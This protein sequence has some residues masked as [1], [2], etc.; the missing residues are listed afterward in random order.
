MLIENSD[1]I[2]C[3]TDKTVKNNTHWT[4][5][6]YN[7]KKGKYIVI[8]SLPKNDTEQ[9]QKYKKLSHDMWLRKMGY[10]SKDISGIK[11][12][13]DKVID[14]KEAL[15]QMQTAKEL[16]NWAISNGMDNRSAF[17]KFKDALLI[18][19]I[20]YNN[21]RNEAKQAAQDELQAKI[22][23]HVTLY[24]DAK[25]SQDRFAITDKD[26]N[27]LWYG[28]FFDND[29]DYN[30]EQSSGELAAAKK[31]VWLGSKIKEAVNA[32]AIS[33]TLYVDAQWLTYQDKFKQKGSILSAMARKYD[34]DLSVE[35]IPGTE[36]PADEWT[37]SQ[38]FKKWSDNDLAALAEPIQQSELTP[39][40]QKEPETETEPIQHTQSEPEIKPAQPA[41]D[42]AEAE[43][44]RIAEA[45][46]QAEAEALELEMQ[47]T[48]DV[49]IINAEPET[50]QDNQLEEESESN[51]AENIE[52]IT[53]QEQKESE[54]LFDKIEDFGEKIGAARKD[55][56]ERG[57][58]RNTNVNKDTRQK[59]EKKYRVF[60]DDDKD[61]FSVVI[62]NKNFFKT[63]K[64]GFA[65]EAEAYF[66]IPRIEV[67]LN[68]RV[69]R[70]DINKEEYGIFRKW[71]SGK[72]WEIKPGFKTEKEAFEYM[73]K[74][75]QELINFK[76]PR[77]ERP[78]LDKIE[79]TGKEYR[80]GNISP[81]VFQ[82]TF[83]FR[84]GEFGNW[85]PN[86]E[87]QLVLNY[88]YDAFMDLADA[89]Y[90][91]PK[92]ISLG[93]DLSIGFGSRGQGLVSAQAHY[94][95]ERAVINLTRIKGAGALA[96]EWFHAFDHYLARLDGMAKGRDENNF[97]PRPSNE[98][99]HL[100]WAISYNSR[101]QKNILD[102]WSNV[103]ETMTKREEEYKLDVERQ[104]KF[105]N[106]LYEEGKKA[107]ELI[108]K[109]LLEP[110]QWYTDGSA[111]GKRRL[112]RFHK[113]TD[114]QIKQFDEAA[115]KILEGNS[116]EEQ[117]I[118]KEKSNWG[119]S[120][121]TPEIKII[122]DIYKKVHQH[123]ISDYDLSNVRSKG[124]RKAKQELDAAVNS[125]TKTRKVSTHFY[126]DAKK[127]DNTRSGT[128][129]ASPHEMMARCFEAFIQDKI[130]K[131]GNLS[132]YLVHSTH[133]N[134]YLICI[135]T[136]IG[137]Y[138]DKD[139]RTNINN[140]FENLFKEI[141]DSENIIKCD[142]N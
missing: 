37:V 49:T 71:S 55:L 88:A 68:H 81:K 140:S 34:I 117:W 74:Y 93:G 76:T 66:A 41:N 56:A 31:A 62:V 75:P 32:P 138:P 99:T 116:G 61:T 17:P 107:L 33:M 120:W 22:T 128:Y 69:Y 111:Y 89:I 4:L 87:R 30:G 38:G 135:L 64:T 27:V 102:K 54:E 100:S 122:A 104:T 78:H 83:G 10:L 92:D 12:I 11:T 91:K 24:S 43:R 51:I 109:S 90:I 35:W 108:R 126:N 9:T 16:R 21:I 20:D 52:N 15:L 77:I 67:S 124:I 142:K 137:I 28:R 70:S 127:M 3:V 58:K 26:G 42:G 103:I 6:R 131:A 94:E 136:G 1:K 114:E 59:W 40:P 95:P 45:E 18:I 47:L 48:D 118:K 7:A 8:S 65:S 57:F 130:E 134:E 53:E 2:H 5:A 112:S 106:T 121:M 97:F 19:G 29:T 139:E 141:R 73:F 123:K 133:N 84:G 98:K 39:E 110:P 132:Q 119:G 79:R 85:L 13:K 60:P 72:L 23:H 96:H 50:E 115:E 125:V 63:I 14:A 46:A 105:F 44:I 113:A 129:W 101:I 82:E 36:N 80:T 25:A 86:D